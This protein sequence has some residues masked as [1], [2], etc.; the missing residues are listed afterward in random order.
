MGGVAAGAIHPQGLGN[1]A[2][3]VTCDQ[4][5]REALIACLAPNRRVE[6]SGLPRP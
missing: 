2:P 1:S 4:R 5:Q 3:I 6:L